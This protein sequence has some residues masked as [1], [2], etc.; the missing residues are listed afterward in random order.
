[1]KY[2]IRESMVQNVFKNYMDSQYDLKYNHSTREF[3]NVK[4]GEIFG[5]ILGGGKFYQSDYSQELFLEGMFGSN[6]DKLLLNYLIEK[7]PEVD[8]RS[9]GY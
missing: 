4:D 3:I 2:I 5:Y 9:T 6:M 8:I 7:F 1:M